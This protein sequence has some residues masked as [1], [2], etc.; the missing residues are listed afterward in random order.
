MYIDIDLQGTPSAQRGMPR[1]PTVP[2]RLFGS[3]GSAPHRPRGDIG[4]TIWSGA[5]VVCPSI[6]VLCITNPG[7]VMLILNG[8][9]IVAWRS[10]QGRCYGVQKPRGLN[11]RRH[12]VQRNQLASTHIQIMTRNIIHASISPGRLQNP[13]AALASNACNQSLSKKLANMASCSASISKSAIGV[14][15]TAPA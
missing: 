13:H 14:W 5:S 8:L 2:L 12:V 9:S 7:T 1:R 11:N 10:T 3:G 4:L 15:A 6:Q